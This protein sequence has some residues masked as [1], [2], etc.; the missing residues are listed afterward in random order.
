MYFHIP[1]PL[2]PNRNKAPG[3][4]FRDLN[5]RS[6]NQRS[7]LRPRHLHPLQLQPRHILRPRPLLPG[8]RLLL[9][10]RDGL[11]NVDH[12]VVVVLHQH[13]LAHELPTLPGHRPH[14][15]HPQSEPAG[16]LRLQPRR[17]PSTAVLGEVPQ[18]HP[19]VP[20]VADHHPRRLPQ[21]PRLLDVKVRRVRGRYKAVHV[22][23]KHVE[24]VLGG[25]RQRRVRQRQPQPSKI[26]RTH[27]RVDPARIRAASAGRLGRPPV[28]RP[29]TASATG[30]RDVRVEHRVDSTR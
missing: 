18:A 11:P 29:R 30:L 5:R 14:V 1:T 16:P 24:P 12:R 19:H 8:A 20:E 2:Q 15:R 28:G 26:G 3:S 13:R 27:G 4:R 22:V 23:V 7:S 17:Q 6:L 9:P 21:H 25:G 10:R